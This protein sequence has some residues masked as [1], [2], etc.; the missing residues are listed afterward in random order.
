VTAR[1]TLKK[2]KRD[3]G[4]E[5]RRESLVEKKNPSWYDGGKKES[6]NKGTGEEIRRK[7]LVEKK[8]HELV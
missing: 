4:R 5:T 7:I 3:R 2:G 1:K 8:R 6:K